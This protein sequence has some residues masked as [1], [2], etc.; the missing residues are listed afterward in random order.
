VNDRQNDPAPA[1]LH[2]G[3]PPKVQGGSFGQGP[4]FASTFHLSGAPT[5]ETIFYG[6]NRNPTW[7][8]L[9]EAIGALE[10]G[11]AA[12]FPSGM[13]AGAAC[14]LPFLRPGDRLLLPA[15]GY[16][17]V[18]SF[19]ETFLRPLGIVVETAPTAGLEERDLAGYRLVWVETPANPGLELCHIE[20]V[21]RKVQG[22]GG[23]LV[24]D[25]TT[26]TPLGQRCLSLG[27]DL[28]M[29]SDTKALSGHSDLLLGHVATRDQRLLDQVLSWRT[30]SGSIVGPMEAWLAHRGL[31]TL[32]LRLERMW[33]TAASLAEWL[34]DNPKL[35][36][37]HYPG[38]PDWPGHDL[39]KRQMRG[40]GSLVGLVFADQPAA[41]RFLA[42][43]TLTFEATSFG[44]T[45]S[46]AER[47]ARWDSGIHPGFVRFSTGCEPTDAVLAD[48]ERALEAV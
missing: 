16:Y 21:A 37:L 32:E 45:H 41:E 39:A 25:N 28:V 20:A 9:E 23:L 2:A 38:L 1:W 17:A 8:A 48:V 40:F 42:G 7:T 33:R 14:L 46:M 36:A 22:S 30:L 11:Q 6:R 4:V 26:M 5:P 31:Q 13:A 44:G 3:L 19:A 15:D 43:L 12:I 18:R 47:R 29:A 35:E 34:Q 27:A 10:G 24:C